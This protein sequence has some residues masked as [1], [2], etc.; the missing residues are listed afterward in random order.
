MSSS[1]WYQL[2]MEWSH[3]EKLIIKPAQFKEMKLFR[4]HTVRSECKLNGSQRVKVIWEE[5]KS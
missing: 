1:G 3:N 2:V 5:E 4:T